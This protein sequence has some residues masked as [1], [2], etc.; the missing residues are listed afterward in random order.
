MRRFETPP[1]HQAQVDWGD[2]GQMEAIVSQTVDF[3]RQDAAPEA[4]TRIDLAS[5]LASLCDD[6]TDAGRLAHY[7]GP[8]ALAIRGQPVGLRRAFA[9]LIDNAIAYGSEADVN[10]ESGPVG[11]TVRVSDRGPGIPE[12]ELPRVME[13][14]YRLEASRNRDTGG[15][16]LGLAIAQQLAASI[17]ATLTLRNREGGGLAAEVRLPRA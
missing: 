7:N 5:L 1:G 2:V 16:G 12:T 8:A 17:G 15:T 6:Q 10:L 3:A 11:V 4:V 9:N 13:P 14:F